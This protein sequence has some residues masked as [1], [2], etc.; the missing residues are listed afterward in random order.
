[1]RFLQAGRFDIITAPLAR[2]V[3][4][5]KDTGKKWPRKTMLRCP[6]D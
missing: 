6:K 4:D 2:A 1:M 5:I 3:Y